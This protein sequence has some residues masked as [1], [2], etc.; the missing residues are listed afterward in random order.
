MD[1]IHFICVCGFEAASA[2]HLSRHKTVAHNENTLKCKLC[3]FVTVYQTNLLR[4]RRE[5][6][7]ILGPRGNK[8]CKFCGF[9]S[10]D[11]EILIQ[12]Q[13]DAHGEILKSAQEKFAKEAASAVGDESFPVNNS[14]SPVNNS[15]SSSISGNDSVQRTPSHHR[16]EGETIAERQRVMIDPSMLEDAMEEDEDEFLDWKEGFM[17]APVPNLLASSSFYESLPPTPSNSNSKKRQR[18]SANADFT[19]SSF[20]SYDLSSPASAANSGGEYSSRPTTPVGGKGAGL[21]VDTSG[22]APTRIRRQYTCEQCSFRTINP[23]EFLYHRRDVH[24][25]KVK[26]VECPY[27]V[28]A[29]QYFQK[30]QVCICRL[31]SLSTRESSILTIAFRHCSA[32]SFLS[33]NWRRAQRDRE[34]QDPIRVVPSRTSRFCN[35]AAP[36]PSFIL[37]APRLQQQVLRRSSQGLRL[38]RLPPR[39]SRDSCSRYHSSSQESPRLKWYFSLPNVTARRLVRRKRI[40]RICTPPVSRRARNTSL[41]K[42]RMANTRMVPTKKKAQTMTARTSSSKASSILPARRTSPRNTLNAIPAATL[43]TFS[44]CSRS[45]SNITAHRRSSARSATSNRL[46]R[47]M[48]SVT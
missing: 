25:A 12:H 35:A 5:V 7:G 45:T 23:R 8:T 16:D 38:R 31:K 15:P 4:H 22:L 19:S 26:I 42:T 37:S 2:R 30:L 32:I 13:R 40:S 39:E 24:G 44:I 20:N 34:P 47:G 18:K 1:P 27:C 48:W 33:I 10:V 3:P 41:P 11:S 36:A 28:Y 17:D 21:A 14:S 9:A 6:H 43:L 46:T 29:C